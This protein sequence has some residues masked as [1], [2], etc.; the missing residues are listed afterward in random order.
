MQS[1]VLAK[2]WG[3]RTVELPCFSVDRAVTHLQLLTIS[4]KTASQHKY[5][6]LIPVVVPT[7]QIRPSDHR[8]NL[9]TAEA[10][11]QTQV[12]QVPAASRVMVGDEWRTSP[13]PAESMFKRGAQVM[14]SPK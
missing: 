5:H 10:R 14:F 8:S 13:L 6:S 7:A 12:V 1:L 11:G 2:D 3:L 4:S 9:Q